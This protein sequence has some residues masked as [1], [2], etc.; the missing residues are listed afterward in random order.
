MPRL[1]V[2]REEFGNGKI[3]VVKLLVLA[4]FARSNAEGRRLV[5]QG[6]VRLNQQ[7]ILSDDSDVE[8]RD[9][10]VLQAGKR[11]FARIVIE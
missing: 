8:V 3:W 5:Q 11:R 9:G 6:G 10:D 1:A 4:G 2:N 7:E